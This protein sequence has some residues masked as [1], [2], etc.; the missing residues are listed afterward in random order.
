LNAPDNPSTPLWEQQP[1]EPDLW[2]YRFRKFLQMG[3]T[4]TVMGA[5]NAD[6]EERG[7]PKQ[8]R[9]SGAWSRAA[10]EFEWRARAAAFDAYQFAQSEAARAQERR[11]DD[12]RWEK[13]ERDLRERAFGIAER[14]IEKAEGMLQFPLIER[15]VE[16]RKETVID[17]AG[18]EMEVVVSTTVIRPGRWTFGT[19]PRLVAGADLIA[20][21]A[22]DLR[23]IEMLKQIE[24]MTDEQ[25]NEEMRAHAAL[26]DFTEGEVL[27]EDAEDEAAAKNDENGPEID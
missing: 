24:G 8:P 27:P 19:V 3:T 21:L 12:A 23:T 18:E 1:G 9:P 6:L 4:R 16:E 10:D 2:F 26:A 14:M 22:C 11:D 25:L 17:S 15:K 20:R 5:F 13:R 7:K